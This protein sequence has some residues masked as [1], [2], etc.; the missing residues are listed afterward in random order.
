MASSC[1]PSG[2]QPRHCRLSAGGTTEI[3]KEIIGPGL[4]A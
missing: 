4:R 1:S 2:R 3:M